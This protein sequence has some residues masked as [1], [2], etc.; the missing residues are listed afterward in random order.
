MTSTPVR[1]R[2]S[3]MTFDPKI[4]MGHILQVVT[5]VIF[6]G[7]A[8][9]TYQKDQTVQDGRLN[10]LESTVSRQEQTQTFFQQK[11]E[12]QLEKVGNS[13]SQ[14]LLDLARIQG[15]VKK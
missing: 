1:S 8:Y 10:N 13:Q 2:K 14:I 3:L 7:T 5:L 11:V 12:S 6:A 4:S 15:P 9:G